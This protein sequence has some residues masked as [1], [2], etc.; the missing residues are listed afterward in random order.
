MDRETRSFHVE[1]RSA[2][3][4]QGII[5]GRAI[6]YGAVSESLGGFVE[7]IAA[8]AFRESLATGPDVYLSWSHDPGKVIACE[9]NGTLDINDTP[10]ALTFTARINPNISWHKDCWQAIKDGLVT[11]MSFIFSADKDEQDWD[12]TQQPTLRTVT[13]GK[14][15]EISVGV[16]IPAYADGATASE[17]RN[18][19]GNAAPRTKTFTDAVIEKG[20]QAFRMMEPILKRGSFGDQTDFASMDPHQNAAQ[21]AAFAHQCVES[22]CAAFQQARSFWNDYDGDDVD[23]DDQDFQEDCRAAAQH[24]E[25][26]C[27]RM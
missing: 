27:Q 5:T 1:A 9:Q 17:A 22:A 4:G 7:K 21:Q 14:L 19:R 20:R 23:Y 24:A 18:N 3:D 8:G 6:K 11:T 10:T 13:K 12:D 2:A 16:P 15:W 25:L 26:C